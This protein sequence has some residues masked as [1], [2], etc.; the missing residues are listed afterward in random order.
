MRIN[1]F[2]MRK[3][4]SSKDS[5]WKAVFVVFFLTT[6]HFVLANVSINEIA[7]MGTE[8]SPTDEW[9]ELKN[10]GSEDA[11]LTGWVLEADDAQPAIRLEGMIAAGS[12]FLLE[13]SD[14]E[15]VPDIGA[16][17]IY[18]GAL[19]NSGEILRLKNA[20]GLEVDAVHALDG[21]PAGDNTTKETMQLISEN[22]VT[23]P[24]TP[25]QENQSPASAGDPENTGNKEQNTPGDSGSGAITYLPPESQKSIKAFSGEDIT[26][27]AG[28]MIRFEGTALGWDHEPLDYAK[29][30]FLWNFGDGTLKDGRNV[31]HIYLYPGTYSVKL[32]VVSGK[33]TASDDMNVY[34][35]ENPILINEY[36]A[37][38]N[39]WIELKNPSPSSVD[40]GRWIIK[41]ED[42][43]I[44]VFPEGTV[45]KAKALAVFASDVTGLV[46][47]SSFPKVI[48]Q[49]P[50]RAVAD[51]AG[52]TGSVIDYSASRFGEYV[53]EG[54]PTP[55]EENKRKVQ[56][57][58]AASNQ[59]PKKE[60]AAPIPHPN[61]LAKTND[62]K[63][64]IAQDKP[65][66]ES[67]SDVAGLK[68][69]NIN[70]ENRLLAAVPDNVLLLIASIVAG[71]AVGFVILLVRKPKK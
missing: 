41:S 9:I 53:E 61:S 66:K 23:A 7:W 12:L 26:S 69:E 46:L 31:S 44:F 20:S 6:P 42:G 14:D 55:G 51:E 56:K 19:S 35:K 18:T 36:M 29:V 54:V 4:S 16:D 3:V 43:G 57:E 13:R 5:P 67:A 48:L 2:G 11:D 37:G 10:T 58:T 52:Y 60:P 30:R 65:V 1:K 59:P 22:W 62:V 49:Y 28:A 39:G 15:T 50:N 45:I 27:V 68:P 21:W 47:P 34:V 70:R 33:E 63:A 71:L 24:A 17:F 32:T 38:K 8:A 25:K 40:I 64:D